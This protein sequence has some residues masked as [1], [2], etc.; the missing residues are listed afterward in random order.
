MSPM[1]KKLI[2]HIGISTSKPILSIHHN[3]HKVHDSHQISNLSISIST[4]NS[5][6]FSMNSQNKHQFILV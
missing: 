4:Q 6:L 2:S 5:S 1:A 3:P